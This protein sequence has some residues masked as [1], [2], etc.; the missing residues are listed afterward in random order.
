ML[1]PGIAAGYADRRTA[2]LD[3]PGV[4][5]VAEGTFRFDDSGQGWAT[6]TIVSVSTADLLAQRETVTEEAFGP[7]S[8]VVEYGPDDDLA[9]VADQVFEG[10]LTGT[11]HAGADEDS[12]SLRSLV[13]WLTGTP[14]GCCS[15]AGRRVS[16]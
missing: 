11:L 9:A 12:P 3:T 7:L 5:A 15:E 10:N 2:I 4:T 8:V 6:P 16:R 1:Y 13:R 14:D